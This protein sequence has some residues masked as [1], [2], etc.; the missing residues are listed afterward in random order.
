[1]ANRANEKGTLIGILDIHGKEIK[2][3]DI[4]KVKHINYKGTPKEEVAEEFIARVFYHEFQ[5]TYRYKPGG[6]QDA[7]DTEDAS[8]IF[9][10]RSSSFEIIQSNS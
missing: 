2:N 7:E 4:I 8:Y 5:A 10:H 3:G 9:N 6:I 1:M